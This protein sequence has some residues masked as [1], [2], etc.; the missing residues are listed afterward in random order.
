MTL[1][2]FHDAVCRKKVC[3]FLK[4][5]G[6]QREST[7]SLCGEHMHVYGGGIKPISSGRH[8]QLLYL[9]RPVCMDECVLCF[10]IWVVSP[11]L[12][13]CMAKEDQEKQTLNGHTKWTMPPPS[14]PFNSF[15]SFSPLQSYSSFAHP[16]GAHARLHTHRKS[17]VASSNGFACSLFLCRRKVYIPLSAKKRRRN[18]RLTSL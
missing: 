18:S 10:H 15:S 14:S 5:I 13:A 17:E 3:A 8:Q 6:T 4:R 16:L 11:P 2:C 9:T 1:R 12:C 7:S